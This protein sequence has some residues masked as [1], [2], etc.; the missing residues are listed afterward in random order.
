MWLCSLQLITITCCSWHD[1]S[2]YGLHYAKWTI[3]VMWND[4][5]SHNFRIYLL[6]ECKSVY[7]YAWVGIDGHIML[8]SSFKTNN[9]LQ[10][11]KIMHHKNMVIKTTAF[12]SHPTKY[13]L[14]NWSHFLNQ[15][16]HHHK[17]NHYKIFLWDIIM[18][19]N[20]WYFADL[21]G[22]NITNIKNISTVSVV[23]VPICLR[24]VT[25]LLVRSFV[26]IL[27][28][29]FLMVWHINKRPREH[30]IIPHSSRDWGW[31]CKLNW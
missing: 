6:I 30:C 2:Y 8:W 21:L 23:V 16:N 18:C 4:K 9:F 29:I 28:I 7:V 12:W 27:L 1:S 17:T 31:K 13:I 20:G 11:K 3:F 26:W 14:I 19:M 10:T 24:V 25:V 22:G 15:M 5:I